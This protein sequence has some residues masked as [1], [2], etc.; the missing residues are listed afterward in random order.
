[1]RRKEAGRAK[2]GGLTRQRHRG[3][4]QG[5]ENCVLHVEINFSKMIL[6]YRSSNTRFK[7]AEPLRKGCGA[8]KLNIIE[9][10]RRSLRATAWGSSWLPSRAAACRLTFSISRR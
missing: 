7:Q 2:A 9:E 10:R 5:G 8:D 3:D 1:V 4:Q 6:L